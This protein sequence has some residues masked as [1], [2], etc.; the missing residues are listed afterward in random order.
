[1]QHILSA[2]DSRLDPADVRHV[3]CGRERGT[4]AV[5][6]EPDISEFNVLDPRIAANLVELFTKARVERPV[7]RSEKNGVYYL[8]TRYEG[9]VAVGR[10]WET[11]ASDRGRDIPPR[12]VTPMPSVHTDPPI[13]RDHRSRAFKAVVNGSVEGR[14]LTLQ[15]RVGVVVPLFEGARDTTKATFARLTNFRLAKD[16]EEVWVTGSSRQLTRLDV[17]YEVLS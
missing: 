11:F 6:S 9:C 8:V 15:G 4:A 10:D 5:T 12:P 16:L 2:Y 3:D 14:P 17:T 13:Q 7:A 1:L